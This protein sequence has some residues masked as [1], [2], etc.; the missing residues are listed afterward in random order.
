[1]ARFICGTTEDDERVKKV[2]KLI[3]KIGNKKGADYA[4]PSFEN[5]KVWDFLLT[6][7]A[8]FSDLNAANSA[9]T[10]HLDGTKIEKGTMFFNLNKTQVFKK[11][12]SSIVQNGLVFESRQCSIQL[13]NCEAVRSSGHL[14]K[15]RTSQVCKVTE[16]LLKCCGYDVVESDADVSINVGCSD[17]NFLATRNS[18]GVPLQ[19]GQMTSHEMKNGVTK[20]ISFGE[21]YGQMYDALASVVDERGTSEGDERKKQIHV[22]TCAELQFQC[23]FKNIRQPITLV[24]SDK[25]DASFVLYNNARIVQVFRAFKQNYD[26]DL[27]DI[28]DID[29]S[30]L[31]ESEEWDLVFHSVLP[32]VDF[33]A[34]FNE[35]ITAAKLQSLNKMCFLL[36]GL[37]N[38]FSKYYRRVR[39][40]RD[41]QPQ[42]LNV[43]YA[44]LYLIL[45][46]RIV[47]EHAFDILGI[48][49]LKQM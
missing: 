4:I 29:F 30:A 42:L 3:R 39:I 10:W 16:R 48:R 2:V 35:E 27:P 36:I 33:L 26:L 45:T 24:V 15:I 19:V 1:M 13:K 31:V 22:A 47:N 40:L 12:I 18:G 25:S 14:N 49:A 37:A 43:M 38:C 28:N 32:Y 46:L 21:I 11:V 17:A 8:N 44:R 41:P 20:P 9:L 6:H 7:P 5:S 34:G 23:L